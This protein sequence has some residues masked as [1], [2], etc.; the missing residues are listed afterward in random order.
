MPN[1]AAAQPITL[2]LL[3]GNMHGHLVL[4]SS[5]VEAALGQA[6]SG[7][8]PPLAS[9]GCPRTC[10]GACQ[11]ALPSGL[12]LWH[13][14]SLVGQPDALPPPPLG[15]SRPPFDVPLAAFAPGPA[16]RLHAWLEG[17]GVRLSDEK[18]AS[19][20][21]RRCLAGRTA[22]ELA[23]VLGRPAVAR[24]LLDLRAAVRPEAWALVRGCPGGVRDELAA[25]LVATQAR[26]PAVLSDVRSACSACHVPT[27]C[28]AHPPCTPS[29]HQCLTQRPPS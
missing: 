10:S 7:G 26:R 29:L 8:S 23:V 13:A 25:L 6:A 14:A 16:Y 9:W 28:R 21:Y 3:L 24:R 4:C 12:T 18:H 20:F 5:A 22:L 17:R 11:A 2:A 1:W 27:T 15:S 19:K